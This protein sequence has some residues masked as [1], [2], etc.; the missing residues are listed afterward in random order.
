MVIVLLVDLFGSHHIVLSP[1]QQA[2]FLAVVF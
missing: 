2:V 1:L